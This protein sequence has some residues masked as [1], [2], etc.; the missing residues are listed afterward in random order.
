V[1]EVSVQDNSA[2]QDGDIH[3][4]AKEENALHISRTTNP[5]EYFVNL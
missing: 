3:E 2:K 4:L 5:I 1:S